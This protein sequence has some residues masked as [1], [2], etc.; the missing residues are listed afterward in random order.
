MTPHTELDPVRMKLIYDFAADR[1]L[2][3]LP[4]EHFMEVTPQATQRKITVESFD[5]IHEARPD[6]QCFNELLVQYPKAGEDP[7][8]PGQ[9][10]PDNMVVVHREPIKALTN[11]ATLL[12]PAG[13][14]LVME[15]VSKHSKRKDYEVSYEKYEKEL[16]VP[17]YLAF[18]PDADELTL[19]QL[20]DGKYQAV[21]P[22]AAG[23]YAIPELELEVALL[24]GWMRYWFRGQLLPLP[25]DLLRQLNAVRMQLESARTQLNAAQSKLTATQGKLT[26]TEQQL[27]AKTGELTA[28]KTELTAAKTE[29]TAAQEKLNAEAAAK[30]EAERR[31]AAAEAELARLR[32][33]LKAKKPGA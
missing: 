22:N 13:P 32:E 12:Q 18:Y 33:E 24:D 23:R 7:D 6:V 28:A 26:A 15:Y 2:R 31:A 14:F 8:K 3:S 20:R 5:L 29:L 27:T 19:F 21:H 9:V 30:A 11:F 17:Y 4:P 25:G 10:V 16:K 1:Y